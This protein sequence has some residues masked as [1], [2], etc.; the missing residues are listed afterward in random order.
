MVLRNNNNYLIIIK[1]VLCYCHNLKPLHVTHNTSYTSVT[2]QIPDLAIIV[3]DEQDIEKG[4]IKSSAIKEIDSDM[5]GTVTQMI[6]LGDFEGKW[7]QS[8]TSLVLNQKLLKD[9]FSLALA[10]NLIIYQHG[11]DISGLNVLKTLWH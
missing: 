8:S 2:N 1:E 7:L 6:A 4:N 10:A 3:I 11:Q 5:G 9:A